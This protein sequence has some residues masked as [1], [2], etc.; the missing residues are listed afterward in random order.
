MITKEW[1]GIIINKT[2]PELK[3][4]LPPGPWQD[5]PDVF[6]Y[7]DEY[8]GY[9]CEI[10]RSVSSG[11]LCGYVFVPLD[12]P[13]IVKRLADGRS[14]FDNPF[15]VH[16]GISYLKKSSSHN[17]VYIIG[18]DCAHLGDYIPIMGD[19]EWGSIY[20]SFSYVKRETSYLARQ[21]FEY[22]K[23]GEV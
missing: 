2:D 6:I 20:R 1:A 12:H 16:G 23:K 7:R 9:R 8:S 14:L 13:F 15:E 17:D 21:L 19:S 10:Q 5:E 22:E 4:S 18:F 11:H 3:K